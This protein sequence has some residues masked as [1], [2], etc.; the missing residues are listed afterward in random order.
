MRDSDI[1]DWLLTY[2]PKRYQKRRK[3]NPLP[4]IKHDT[5]RPRH[6][7]PMLIVSP[8]KERQ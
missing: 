1:F 2:K 4:L 5:S 6:R 7:R 8:G 3:R